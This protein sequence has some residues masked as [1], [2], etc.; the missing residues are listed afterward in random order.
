MTTT[1]TTTTTTPAEAIA[2]PRSWELEADAR[3]YGMTT[4]ADALRYEMETLARRI[5]RDMIAACEHAERGNG[6]QARLLVRAVERSCARMGHMAVE[7]HG[8]A[9][10]GRDEWYDREMRDDYAH[11]MG[12]DD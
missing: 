4:P 1:T 9:S 8:P 11:A 10:R 2:E 7:W 3:C 12:Y 5:A 6:A